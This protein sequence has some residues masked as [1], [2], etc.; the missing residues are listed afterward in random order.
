M[1][2][3]NSVTLTFLGNSRDLERSIDNVGRSTDGLS[4]KL[5]AQSLAIGKASLFVALGAGALAMVGPVGAAT[6]ALGAFGTVALA[7]KKVILDAFKPVEK[8]F[9]DVAKALAPVV[10]GV[11]KLGAKVVRDLLPAL[12]P[13]AKDGAKVISAFLKPLDKLVRSKAFDNFVRVAGNLATTIGPVL[14]RALVKIV[15]AILD[16]IT[17]AGPKAAPVFSTLV[18][19]FADLVQNAVPLATA[20]IG[21]VGWLVKLMNQSPAIRVAIIGLGIAIGIAWAAATDGIGPLIG[22]IAVAVLAIIGLFKM[23]KRDIGNFLDSHKQLKKK[24]TEVWT[25]VKNFLHSAWIFI[26]NQVIKP[27]VSAFRQMWQQLKQFWKQHGD[28]IKQL[29][30]KLWSV[31]KRVAKIV[32]PIIKAITK[33]GLGTVLT[34]IGGLFK[35]ILGVAGVFL[36]VLT[37]HWGRAFRGIVKLGH[38]FSGTIGAIFRGIGAAMVAPISAAVAAIRSIWNSTLGGKG[39]S[40]PSWVPGI[41]GDSFRLPTFHTGGIVGGSGEQL[42]MVK[43]GEGVFTPQQMAAM[44]GRHV[45]IEI[46]AGDNSELTRALM[47]VMQ[48]AVR[49]NGGD[50]AMF[51]RKVAFA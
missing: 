50:P 2:G 33:S 3:K 7:N 51:Q 21:I 41:G 44:G 37:G 36:D 35:T 30:G 11:A 38:N 23:L 4:A 22:L 31:I 34:L 25:E 1:A 17:K 5:K 28:E 16:L 8:Q 9:K 43:G 13:L 26:K 18:G 45:V 46:R 29:W 19:G 40:I 39:F 15:G 42:A 6:V 20:V 14:G 49:V 27:L 32:W 10:S 24:I 47:G 12:T 48:K